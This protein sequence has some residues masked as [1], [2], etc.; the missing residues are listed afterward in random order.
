VQ[1]PAQHHKLSSQSYLHDSALML[2]NVNSA[3]CKRLLQLCAELS[4]HAKMQQQLN[5]W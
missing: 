4:R 3:C 2:T 1:L 5:S